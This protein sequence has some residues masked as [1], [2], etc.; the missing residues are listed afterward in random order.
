MNNKV[1]IVDGQDLDESKGWFREANMAE[2]TVG[3]IQVEPAE[4]KASTHDRH[5]QRWAGN[6]EI[7]QKQ[8]DKFMAVDD[9][10]RMKLFPRYSVR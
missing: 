1:G 7:T 2:V 4:G 3:E 6:H 5:H 9:Y 8:Y 10:H